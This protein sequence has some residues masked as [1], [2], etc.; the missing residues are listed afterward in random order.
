M[1]TLK[2]EKQIECD[3][4]IVGKKEKYPT[5]AI[6]LQ[7]INELTL[8]NRKEYHFTFNPQTKQ[9]TSDIIE[10]HLSSS[11]PCQK[12]EN[13]KKSITIHSHVD[14]QF[15]CFPSPSDI[16]DDFIERDNPEQLISCPFEKKLL[17]I[18]NP[19][20]DLKTKIF[21]KAAISET[22]SSMC[23]EI[24]EKHANILKNTQQK[25]YS[26]YRNQFKN[27]IKIKKL[28]K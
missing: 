10:G 21:I 7:K 23:C 6:A 19:N 2:E 18:K 12:E 25:Y 1:V 3:N 20:F 28:L 5:F 27:N 16:W 14:D 17:R 13:H 4:T 11:N 22:I 8:L 24:N 9:T 15:D 26:Q